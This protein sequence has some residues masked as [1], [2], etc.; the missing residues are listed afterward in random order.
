M[1]EKINDEE[2]EKLSDKEKLKERINEEEKINDKEEISEKKEIVIDNKKE[3]KKVF[4]GKKLVETGDNYMAV[5]MLLG[6]CAGMVMRGNSYG[7]L[8]GMCLGML[9][10]SL[11]NKEVSNDDKEYLNYLKQETEDMEKYLEESE[12][13]DYSDENIRRTTEN[14]LE[15]VNRKMWNKYSS[16]IEGIIQYRGRSY[17][18]NKFYGDDDE[19]F[20]RIFEHDNPNIFNHM[21]K[22]CKRKYWKNVE[23]G[24]EEWQD[25]IVETLYTYVRDEISHSFDVNADIITSKASDVLKHKTGMC[26][27]K[28]NLLAAMLRYAGIPTGICYE[29]LSWKY[30]TGY[31]VHGFNA[32]YIN[33]KW[34]FIDARGNKE[35]VNAWFHD[36]ES[37]LA[38]YCRK[39]KD[40]YFFDTIYVQPDKAVIDCIN[41]AETLD[42]IR[43]SLP[44]KV[45]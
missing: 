38:S 19:A 22:T 9:V 33:K 14:L 42:D 45:R 1:S 24:V 2:K 37:E 3:E 30:G 18:G 11:I 4:K 34:V 43:N 13:I 44:D 21:N 5:G 6:M 25:L 39:D 7:Y 17:T 36:G 28:A 8:I 27:A 31:F 35:G 40:E 15:P 12:Y 41:N 32:V 16:C 23:K 26:H 20:R 10:G 29:R